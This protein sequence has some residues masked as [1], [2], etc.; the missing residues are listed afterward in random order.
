MEDITHLRRV[1]WQEDTKPVFVNPDDGLITHLADVMEAEMLLSARND[2]RR[3]LSLARDPGVSRAELL[4]AVQYL[5]S[6]VQDAALVADLRGERLPVTEPG[7]E[8]LSE[9]LWGDTSRRVGLALGQADTGAD[10]PDTEAVT[11]ADS[12]GQ[13]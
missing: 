11:D 7:V 4:A 2:A 9:P 5:S 10:R 12:S 6:A 13:R 8:D 3:A 1:P